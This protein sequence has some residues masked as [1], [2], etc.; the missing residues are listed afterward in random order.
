DALRAGRPRAGSWV[1]LLARLLEEIGLLRLDRRPP[2]ADVI[3]F[4]GIVER[5]KADVA[6]AERFVFGHHDGLGHVVEIDFDR[7]V[8]GLAFQLYFVPNAQAP[9]DAPGRF[10]SEILTRSVLHDENVEGIRVRGN[11]HV[12]VVEIRRILE[13]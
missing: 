13:T 6:G 9:R 3:Y 8:C 2:D 4:A 5:A 11:G 7:A 10:F 12:D 1:G